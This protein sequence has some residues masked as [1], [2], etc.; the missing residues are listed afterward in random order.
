MLSAQWLPKEQAH[1]V[2][3]RIDY[4]D[5]HGHRSNKDGWLSKRPHRWQYLKWQLAPDLRARHSA[6]SRQRA[7]Q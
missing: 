4:A 5:N 3:E 6:E 1:I 7:G 2:E